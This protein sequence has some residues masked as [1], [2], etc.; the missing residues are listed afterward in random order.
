MLGIASFTGIR[1]IA[2]RSNSIVSTM[3]LMP[4]WC[5]RGCVAAPATAVV[6]HTFTTSS[7]SLQQESENQSSSSGDIPAAGDGVESHSE[8][9]A[10]LAAHPRTAGALRL[11]EEEKVQAMGSHEKRVY[12]QRREFNK[13][14]ASHGRRMDELLN[15]RYQGWSVA[16]L[17]SHRVQQRRNSGS[18]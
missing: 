10:R 9:V 18:N 8:R 4:I 13:A 14:L 16:A 17:I 15:T 3:T 6:Q 5:M 2:H 12:T 11:M 7:S 1:V